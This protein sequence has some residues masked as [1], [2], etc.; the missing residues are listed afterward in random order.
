VE[1]GGF[2]EFSGAHEGAAGGIGD[3][4]ESFF[5]VVCEFGFPD[6]FVWKIPIA[7]PGACCL[8]LSI[9]VSW[10]WILKT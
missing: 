8:I 1:R 3:N 6:F 5:L 10:R 2:P 4:D 7:K 9:W